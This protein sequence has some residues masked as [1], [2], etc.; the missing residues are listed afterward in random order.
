M[1]GYICTDISLLTNNKTSMQIQPSMLNKISIPCFIEKL[2]KR[3]QKGWLPNQPA[4]EQRQSKK[5]AYVIS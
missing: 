5:L 3:E 2:P 1:K 4:K